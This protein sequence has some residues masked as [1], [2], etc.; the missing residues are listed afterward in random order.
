MALQYNPLCANVLGNIDPDEIQDYA[1]SFQGYPGGLIL[2]TIEWLVDGPFIVDPSTPAS[3]QGLTVVDDYTGETW[4][5]C[6][7]VR[8]RCDLTDVEKLAAVGER[9][10]VTLRFTA[11]DGRSW[12]RSFYLDVAAK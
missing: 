5:K 10:Q 7:R 6:E 1:I 9:Q 3:P 12:D 8:L 11:S 4:L 2:Q